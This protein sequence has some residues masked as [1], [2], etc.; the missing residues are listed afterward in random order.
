[1]FALGGMNSC[2]LSELGRLNLEG[3]LDI[4]GLEN[5]SEATEAR[6]ANLKEKQGLHSLRLSWDLNAYVKPR[7]PCNETQ[8]EGKS[9]KE[10]VEALAAQDW[11][12][13]ADLVE[14]VFG[15]LQPHEKLKVLEIEG[16][17][18]KTLPWW[19]MES[20]PPYLAEL[21]LSSCV[22]CVHLSGLEQ[23]HSLRVLKLIMLPAVK[24]LPALG[25]LPY[26]KV[27]QLMLPAVRCLGSEFYGGEGAFPSLEELALALMSDLEEW[28]VV[29]S[30]EFLPRL[31]K[32]S[33]DECPKLRALPS[34][35]P[36]VRELEMNADDGLLLSSLHSGAFPNLKHLHVQNCEYSNGNDDCNDSNDGNDHDDD[37]DDGHDDRNNDDDNNLSLVPRVLAD[38]MRSLGSSSMHI[39]CKPTDFYSLFFAFMQQAIEESKYDSTPGSD[40]EE[41]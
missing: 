31:S 20:S 37:N 41:S 38:R 25:Q 13:D 3:E 1:M 8:N 26:L 19:L 36:S 2:R 32:L 22:R 27:L 5:A 35:F 34:A 15:D 21:S 40:L 39:K 16:Y 11:D 10:L 28:T 23:L 7:Q 6:K 12:A 18:G 17:V 29:G 24:C 4:R 14:D 33:I 30:G 9:M